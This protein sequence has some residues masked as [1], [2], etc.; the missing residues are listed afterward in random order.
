[1]PK[2][3]KVQAGYRARTLSAF[4]GKPAPAAAPR[5]D[6]PAINPELTKAR[7]F[8]YLDLVMEFAPPSPEEATIRA[9]LARI[10]VGTEGKFDPSSLSPERRAAIAAGMKSGSDKVDARV[11]TL[12]ADINGWR[13]SSSFGNRAFFNGDWLLRAAAARAGIYGLDAEEAMYPMTRNA[14]DGSPLDGSKHKYTITFAKGQL[15][16]V[17]A[18][19]SVTMY[20][21]KTQFLVANPLDRYLIN[22]TML[23]GMRLGADGSLTIYVQKDSPGKEKESNWLPAPNGPMFIAMRLY[24]PKTEPP[25]IL[26]PGRGTWSPPKVVVAD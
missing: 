23:D 12:G 10:G 8:E 22:S 18:F 14:A 16:P 6:W 3:E 7:F 17:N 1:M 9:K 13:V 21:G 5:L 20:D 19:W 24:W 26:P 25:S 15:P 2:V 4:T 11:E